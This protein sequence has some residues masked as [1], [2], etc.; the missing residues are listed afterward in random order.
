MLEPG[1]NGERLTL[2]NAIRLLPLPFVRYLGKRY[3]AATSQPMLDRLFP[4]TD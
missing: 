3:A 2:E 1:K 4:L